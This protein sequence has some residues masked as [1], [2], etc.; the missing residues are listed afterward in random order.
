MSPEPDPN[1]PGLLAPAETSL[2]TDLYELAMA[3]SYHRRDSNEQA[4]FEL[5]ARKL[6]PN[7]DW[8]LAA[9]LGPTLRLVAELRFRAAEL[10]YLSSLGFGD[11]FLGYL[12]EFRFSGDVDALPAPVELPGVPGAVVAVAVELDGDAMGG[13]AAVDPAAAG[14][15]VRL[16]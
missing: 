6:P 1:D 13:P 14:L 16:G 12:A 4:I 10:E 5:F 9:G 7:R 15:S 8:L 3:S 2:L 11:E